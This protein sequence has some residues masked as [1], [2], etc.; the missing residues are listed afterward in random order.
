MPF[1]YDYFT[2]TTDITGRWFVARSA[3]NWSVAEN[4]ASFPEAVRLAK[5]YFKSLPF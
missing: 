2:F 3:D 4:V 5:E 1:D